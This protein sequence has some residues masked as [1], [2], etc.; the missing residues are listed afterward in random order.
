MPASSTSLASHNFLYKRRSLPT[1]NGARRNYISFKKAWTGTISGKVPPEY[2][3]DEIRRCLPSEVE[4]DIKNLVSMTDVWKFLDY[5]YGSIMQLTNEL[6]KSLLNF[7][8]GGGKTD[9]MKFQE[10]YRK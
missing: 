5:E 6:V 1:F 10:L 3:L 8:F 2:E 7:K 4:P 9:Y